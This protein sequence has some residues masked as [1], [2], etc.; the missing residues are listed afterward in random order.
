MDWIVYGI[1]FGCGFI[2]KSTKDYIEE[3]K[4]KQMFERLS[5][6]EKEALATRFINARLNRRNN[7]GNNQHD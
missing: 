3:R 6:V 4:I 2:C 1:W 5:E 7:H